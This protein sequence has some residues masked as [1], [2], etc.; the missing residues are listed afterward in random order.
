MTVLTAAFVTCALFALLTT[1][2]NDPLGIADHN[3]DRPLAQIQ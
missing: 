3:S 2:I 1:E